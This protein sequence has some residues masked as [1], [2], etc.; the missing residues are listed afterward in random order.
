[1]TDY[2]IIRSGRRTLGLQVKDGRVIVRAPRFVPDERIRLLADGRNVLWCDFGPKLLE[3]DGTLAK[4]TAHDFVH[5]TEKGYEIWT[6]ALLPYL[7]C[8]LGF[9]GEP[10]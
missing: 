4:E 8:C 9:S 1:M 7:D 3:P 6:A 2:T 10:P 5:L